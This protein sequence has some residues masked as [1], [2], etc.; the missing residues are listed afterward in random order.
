MTLFRTSPE[1]AADVEAI[2]NKLRE[3]SIGGLVSYTA[4]SA[5]IGRD[6]RSHRHLLDHARKKVESETGS[7]FETL[8][9]IG[10]RRLRSEET[11]TVGLGV[12]RKVRRAARRGVERLSKVRVNDLDRETANKIIAHRSQLGAISLVAD[13]RKSATVAHEAERTGSTIPAGRVLQLFRE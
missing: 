11:H 4:I 5:A 2:A 13:G 8:R 3:A 9:G 1:N 10:I 6:I 12:I 7:L